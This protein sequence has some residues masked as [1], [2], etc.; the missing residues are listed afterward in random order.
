MTLDIGVFSIIISARLYRG[1]SIFTP[2]F[3]FAQQAQVAHCNGDP[4]FEALELC[5]MQ[6]PIPQL[7]QILTAAR[8]SKWLPPTLGS[9]S[10]T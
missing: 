1:L 4:G 8:M 5:S 3:C 6:R 10:Q 7:R 9:F 2:T